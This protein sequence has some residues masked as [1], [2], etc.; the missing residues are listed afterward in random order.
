[1]S[2]SIYKVAHQPFE[3]QRWEEP[4]QLCVGC[5]ILFKKEEVGLL[6]VEPLFSW[7]LTC[8][9]ATLGFMPSP[10]LP[11]GIDWQVQQ[12]LG[13][14]RADAVPPGTVHQMVQNK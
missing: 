6:S 1:M 13:N 10:H 5:Y 11:W 8:L 12:L 4:I 3:V 7:M 9:S 2:I 14:S